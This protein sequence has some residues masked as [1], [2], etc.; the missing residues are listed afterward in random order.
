MTGVFRANKRLQ[1]PFSAMTGMAVAKARPLADSPSVTPFRD[2]IVA[3][4]QAALG[5]CLG[6]HPDLGHQRGV[7][8]VLVK[9]SFTC[10]E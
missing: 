2:R 6:L 4:R 7:F 3:A 5:L 9:A 8:V 10:C 1:C